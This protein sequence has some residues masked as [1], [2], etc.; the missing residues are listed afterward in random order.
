MYVYF[1]DC[2]RF[3]KVKD[4]AQSQD[5]Q[6]CNHIQNQGLDNLIADDRAIVFVIFDAS[7]SYFEK[8]REIFPNVQIIPSNKLLEHLN[9]R[10]LKSK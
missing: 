6:I 1:D 7:V 2:F 4:G 10:V 9:I 5:E 3:E 8:A